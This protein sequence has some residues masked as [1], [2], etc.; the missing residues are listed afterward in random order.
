MIRFTGGLPVLVHSR[1]SPP[2]ENASG[3]D[4]TPLW[5]LRLKVDLSGGSKFPPK[6]RSGETDDPSRGADVPSR[7]G[8]GRTGEDSDASGDREREERQDST[9]ALV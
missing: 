1:R 3:G 8:K 9:S 7:E 6:V 5:D 2:D 4:S